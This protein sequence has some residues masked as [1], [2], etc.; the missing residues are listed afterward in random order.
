M[1][2]SVGL[3]ITSAAGFLAL[4]DESSNQLKVYA[5]E[6]LN[7]IVHQFWAEIADSIEKIEELYEDETFQQRRLAALVAAKVFYHLGQFQLAMTYTLGA[8][9]LFAIHEKNEFV[10][11]MISKCIEEY[12]KLRQELYE[13]NETGPSID[14]RLERIVLGLFDQSFKLGEAKQVLGIALEARRLDKVEEA[15]RSSS[16]K[17]EMLKYCFE[18]AMIHVKSIQFRRSVLQVL[19]TLHEEDP[20]PDFLSICQCLIFLN[21][22]Q[23]VADIL[24]RLASK[25]GDQ[26][27]LAL[28]IAFDLYST[29]SQN[30]L[31]N[32]RTLLP[33]PSASPSTTSGNSESE[34]DQMQVDEP[35]NSTSSSSPTPTQTTHPVAEEN[36][37]SKIKRILSGEVTIGLHLEFLTRNN[38]TDLTILK[39]IKNALEPRNSVCHSATVFANALM[40]CGTTRDTFLRENLEWFSRATN[41][42]K[43]SATAGLGVIH[44]GH[45][46]EGLSLL[47][48]YLPRGSISS[49]YSEGGALYALGLI[50]A[51]H[52]EGITPYLLNSIAIANGSEVVLH[53]VCLGLGVAGMG[54][55]SEEIYDELKSILS[56]SDNAVAGE[57]AGLSMGLINTGSASQKAI[58]DM[59]EYAHNTQHEKIIRGLAI[60]IALTMYSREAESDALVDQLTMDKDPI[61]RYGGMYTIAL[62][63]AGTSNNSAVKRLLHFA[64]SDVSDDVR[65]AA[66][67]ALGFVLFR[68]P[69]QCPRLVSLL[70]ESYNP[71]VR[72]GATL[73]VGISCAGTGLKEA[74]DLLEPMTKDLVDFVRQGAFIALAMVLCQFTKTQE[75][76][77][78]TIRRLFEERIS[79]KH[80]DV[81]AKFGAILAS[82]IIDAG[83]RNVTLSLHSE[84]HSNMSAI[85][86]MAVFTQYWYWYPTI[87]F[88]SLAF[89]PT[90]I[91]GLNKNLKMPKFSF[92]SNAKPSLFAYPAEQKAPTTIA[93][94]KV[95]TAVLSTTLKAKQR[96]KANADAAEASNQK[97]KPGKESE[98]ED[99]EMKDVGTEEEKEKEKK[100]PEPSFE[101]LNNPARVTARQ[102][103]FI[104]FDVD[105]R[106]VPIKQQSAGILLLKD[107]KP[108]E[109]EELV[110][111]TPD[112]TKPTATST[113][114][115]TAKVEPPEPDMPKPFVYSG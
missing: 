56:N 11:T 45:L 106:Y 113:E 69:K 64:V 97:Q 25:E 16:N 112:G 100:E 26:K 14:T 61:L 95:S 78:E 7:Q 111:P 104:S 12:V 83:G 52:G 17:K 1:P 102:F 79:D 8:E 53:G 59:L 82:G 13:A 114:G 90:A 86:G 87:H 32:V 49:P 50:H 46:V 35:S 93:P 81:I 75:P 70:A 92:K 80:E 55:G 39:N 23:T 109:P 68:Q 44:K 94:T 15:I 36:E 58:A 62:A 2:A 91:I 71:H 20:S 60:G 40:H 66:V 105:E 34:G 24:Q 101:L 21:H 54:T 29:A 65:R 88:I 43:F 19:V 98:K 30:F 103:P 85:I 28:Q 3:E 74:I 89:T 76:K 37:I 51:N 77:V 99:K 9:D 47:A 63:Y 27:L 67:M 96:S 115:A 38:H 31:K 107:T 110:L 41:W 73:A 72:Y 108:S 57:A 42:A 4:L 6:R 10:D 22:P 84:G 18:I 48:P 33:D 5:L